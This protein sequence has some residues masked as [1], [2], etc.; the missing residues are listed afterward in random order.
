[1]MINGVLVVENK[2]AGATVSDIHI[3]LQR[4]WTGKWKVKDRTSENLTIKDYAPDP[5]LTALLA[6]YDQRAKDDAVPR[7]RSTACRRPWCRIPLCWT[8][9]TRYRCTTPVLRW[10]QRP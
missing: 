8:S 3:Y 2:N 6:E 4:D 5:E 10:Q 9:S 1:M 7:T